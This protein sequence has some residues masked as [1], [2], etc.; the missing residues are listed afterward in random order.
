MTRVGGDV[1]RGNEETQEAS[2]SLFEKLLPRVINATFS[3]KRIHNSQFSYITG[4]ILFR[5]CR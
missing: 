3:L 5:G 2:M 4:F 1:G